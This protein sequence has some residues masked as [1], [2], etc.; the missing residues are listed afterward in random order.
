MK[1]KRDMKQKNKKAVIRRAF[2]VLREGFFL[3]FDGVSQ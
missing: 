3:F 1:G 2:P